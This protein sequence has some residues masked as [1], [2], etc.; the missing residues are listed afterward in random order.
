[1]IYEVYWLRT[2]ACLA[3]VV[4][5]AVNATLLKYEGAMTQGEEYLLIA[6]RFAVFFG[7]PAFVFISEFLL[8]HAYPQGVPKGFIMIRVKYLLAPFAFMAVVFA[9]V[10][11]H[12]AASFWSE[13][14]L[15]LFMGGYTGYFV[16]IIFQFYLL[17]IVMHRY[18]QQAQPGRV[19]AASF[20]ITA[21]YLLFFH[22]TSPPEMLFG[23]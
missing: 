22:V 7:T 6:I 10:Y 19:I 16:L 21:A 20:V 1:M 3:V 14:G 5:H 9:G 4:I 11:S 8:A 13:L 12:S 17:H 18:L 2:L 15:N 23:E